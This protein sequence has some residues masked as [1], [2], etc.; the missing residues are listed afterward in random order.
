[1]KLV[2]ITSLKGGTGRT[3]IAAN[4]TALLDAG[5]RRAVAVDVDPQNAL[6][7]HFGLDLS[8]GTGI[9]RDDATAG[10]IEHTSARAGG[11]TTF[12][13][14]G[15]T[16]RDE[17]AALD[18]SV[19]RDPQW[20]RRKLRQLVPA[21]TSL[22][23]LDTPS[24]PCALLDQALAL[25]DLVLVVLRPDAASFATIART[26][27]LLATHARPKVRRFY[28]VNGVDG[29]RTLTAD[30]LTSM[31]ALLP[32]VMLPFWL[33]EDEHVREALA[34]QRLLVD[35]APASRALEPLWQLATFVATA[36]DASEP[37]LDEP[38]AAALRAP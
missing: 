16:T 5:D 8:D 18:G 14:F 9:A 2:S 37:S 23:V 31:S 11:R 19:A 6:G 25:S 21:G 34:R 20:L 33:P 27:A 35:D 28:L 32:G 13:P 1:M 4:L 26:E 36:V 22:C 24:T 17:L 3:T 29:R 10:R 30:V 38:R 15:E 7:L 12:V